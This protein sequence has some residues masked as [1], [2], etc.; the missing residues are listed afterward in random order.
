MDAAAL[1]PWRCMAGPGDAGADDA[2]EE[3]AGEA[4]NRDEPA[5][6]LPL[7][8][9]RRCGARR[10]RSQSESGAAAPQ[11]PGVSCGERERADKDA[12]GDAVYRPTGG[13]DP[14]GTGG[15][16]LI[17]AFGWPGQ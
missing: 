15:E 2:A 10:G 16:V 5:R 12:V 7:V 11:Q 4:A 17:V 8:V 3:V 14:T 1:G 13:E 6:A 9:E